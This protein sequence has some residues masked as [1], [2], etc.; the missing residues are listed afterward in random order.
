MSRLENVTKNKNPLP[1]RLQIIKADTEHQIVY[2]VV[3]EPNDIDTDGETIS[4]EHVAKMAWEFLSSGFYDKIDVQHSFKESGSKVVESFVTRKGDEDF[5]EDSWVLGVQTPDDVWAQVKSGDLN[6]FSLA[7]P[8]AKSPQRVI[9]E[10]SKQIVGVT[11]KS[12]VDIIPEHEHTFIVNYNQDGNVMSG[13][14]D[15]CLGHS[16]AIFAETATQKE[17]DHNHRF[18]V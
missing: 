8:A 2:G 18:K 12:T 16:H 9:V 6:G 11:E 15:N 10:I 1:E 13:K 14:T 7:G 5:P 17:L 4:K 3:Y